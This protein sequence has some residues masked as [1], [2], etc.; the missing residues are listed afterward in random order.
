MVQN[1]REEFKNYLDQNDN[2]EVLLSTL[3][4]TAKVVLRGKIIAL[5]SML[6]R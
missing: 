3:W 6:K 2:G 4:E 5:S 1:I